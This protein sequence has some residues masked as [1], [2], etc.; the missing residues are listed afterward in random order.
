MAAENVTM[1][2]TIIEEIEEVVEESEPVTFTI[3]RICLQNIPVFS[4]SPLTA[5]FTPDHGNCISLMDILTLICGMTEPPDEVFPDALCLCCRNG[6]IDAYT[7]RQLAQKSHAALLSG[8]YRCDYKSKRTSSPLMILLEKRVQTIVEEDGESEFKIPSPSGKQAVPVVDPHRPH[9]CPECFKRFYVDSTLKLH[10]LMHAKS[11]TQ[12][13]EVVTEEQ[14]ALY[15]CGECGV[16]F[17]S[18]EDLEQHWKIHVSDEVIEDASEEVSG[19]VRQVRRKRPYQCPHCPKVYQS[20]TVIAGHAKAAHADQE[21]FACGK[22]QLGFPSEEYMQEHNQLIHLKKGP[23][24]FQCSR[25]DKTFR[26]LSNLKYHESVH[27]NARDHQCSV[28]GKGFN[29]KNGL[30]VHMARHTDERKFA[31][32]K[33]PS[34]FVDKASLK[35]HSR[36]HTGEK[37]YQCPHCDAAFGTHFSWSK[38][39]RTHTGERPYVCDICGMRF[40]SSYHMNVSV[41]VRVRSVFLTELINC[42]YPIPASLTDTHRREAVQVQLL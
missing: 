41:L 9:Q 19:T 13:Q 35:H 14:E 33:C 15:H 7:L 20:L 25:C 4:S 31:C 42:K 26:A 21:I 12:P 18:M 32:D 5:Q 8:T 23:M 34:T 38:H 17:D 10:M 1:E 28:C 2:E 3:C 29:H 11:K 24:R 6:L 39:K 37:P 40:N 30:R 27:E 16:D 36:I 22:C